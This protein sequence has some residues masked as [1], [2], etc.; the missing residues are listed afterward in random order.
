MMRIRF[1]LILKIT[2]RA[3]S[4]IPQ[5]ALFHKTTRF[6]SEI[7]TLFRGPPQ[8]FFSGSHPSYSYL[9]SHLRN[10]EHCHLFQSAV[11]FIHSFTSSHLNGGSP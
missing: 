10:G 3:K 9:P 8:S 1:G 4:Y 7:I 11:S 5:T 6:T 2:E